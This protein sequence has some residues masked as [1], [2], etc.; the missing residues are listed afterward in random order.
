MAIIQY[1]AIRFD[2][3]ADTRG[4]KT[5]R[6]DIASLTR[7][8]NSTRTEYE[9]FEKVLQKIATVQKEGSQTDDWVSRAVVGAAEKFIAAERAAG[10]Y[11]QALDMVATRLPELAGQMQQLKQA[12]FTE[13][14][15]ARAA[16]EARK[17]TQLR[18]SLF[19]ERVKRDQEASAIAKRLAKEEAQ[20][21]IE[22]EK[23]AFEQISQ[24]QKQ[25]DDVEAY[26]DAVGRK[27]QEEY[28]AFVVE[29]ETKRLN[30]R[31]KLTAA[32][33][34]Q[35]EVEAPAKDS[36]SLYADIAK[37]RQ[38]RNQKAVDDTKK[39]SDARIKA[40][41][42]SQKQLAE[43]EEF[44][45]QQKARSRAQY[46]ALNAKREEAEARRVQRKR[47]QEED[48]AKRVLGDIDAEAQAKE[49]A[50]RRVNKAL[51]EGLSPVEQLTQRLARWRQELDKGRISA[52][53]FLKIQNLINN[54]IARINSAPSPEGQSKFADFASG[55][56]S[57]LSPTGA[58]TA[59][60]AGFF[61]GQKTVQFAQD[62]VAA[63]V[64][65]EQQLIKLEVILG[66]NRKAMRAFSEL[67]QI[68]VATN[69]T[70]DAMLRGA[71]TMAQFGVT[72]EQLTPGMKNLAIIS[73]GNA[74]RLQSL[75][76]AYGQVAAAGRLTGQETLQFV[77][78]GFNPLQEIARTTGKSMAQLRKEMELGLVTFDMVTGAL[79][80]STEAGGR[81]F[82]MTEKL[83]D[84]ASAKVNKLANE[85]VKLKEA[86]GAILTMDEA[87]QPLTSSISGLTLYTSRMKN[88]FLGLNTAEAMFRT[89][90]RSLSGLKPL[91]EDMQ[92]IAGMQGSKAGPPVMT[93]KEKELE[94]QAERRKQQEQ[95]TKRGIG[96]LQQGMESLKKEIKGIENVFDFASGS[97][98]AYRKNVVAA[99]EARQDRIRDLMQQR[100]ELLGK[101]DKDKQSFTSD[102]PKAVSMGTREAYE[103]VTRTQST[104][105]AKQLEEQRK[106]RLAQELTNKIL[107]ES[108]K[109]NIM[110]ILN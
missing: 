82:G 93:D 37:D 18:E 50:Q 99:S 21:K 5:M 68:A 83:A 84:T 94:E 67:R 36:E 63:F 7:I 81:F 86:V 38:K 26:F 88:D 91:I 69:Q 59:G 66:S 58:L 70:S 46:M 14:E 87:L 55:A 65:L 85:F 62:S 97:A 107:L 22:A 6:T 33:S 2:I 39:L 20:A 48:Y 76:I 79:I 101:G 89:Y 13:Q 43:V 41:K 90:T 92:T 15:A 16:E 12:L 74:E 78:A 95:L 98:D 11:A 56:A 105:Q 27:R 34:G 47:R 75:S 42:E 80:S 29:Q 4:V 40:E 3:Q 109:Q 30:A 73:A 71:V 45:D 106:Q 10:R 110:G 8:V 104:M 23:R 77:N 53:Q 25:A 49:R 1:G 24:L 57:G 60:A 32:R 44:Y 19:K 96:M 61:I 51:Q 52:E 17:E 72:A 102:L 28:T 103:L 35:T 31:R 64:D 9:K 54:E 100:S 108:K